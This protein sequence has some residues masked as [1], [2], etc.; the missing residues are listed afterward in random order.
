MLPPSP[1]P[2]H[3][4]R[5]H[6]CAHFAAAVAATT[7]TLRYANNCWCSEGGNLKD[8]HY[9]QDANATVAFGFDAIK[10]DSCG[11]AKNISAWRAALDVASGALSGRRVELENCRNF[12]FT[13]DLAPQGSCPADL[14]RS[15]EDNAPDF[16]SSVCRCA[17]CRRAAA[18]FPQQLISPPP[19][20]SLV[21]P[22]PS[23]SHG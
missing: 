3:S 12:P 18:L 11:P 8:A 1:L 22:P 16:L 21:R 20:F 19:P 5:A 10:V 7:T 6:S 9:A 15:T 2:A 14:F 13:K 23:H 4:C 17:R